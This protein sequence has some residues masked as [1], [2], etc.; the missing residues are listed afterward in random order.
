[1]EYKN[2]LKGVLIFEIKSLI[3]RKIIGKKPKIFSNKNYLNLGCGSNYVDGYINADFFYRFK[4]WKKYTKKLEWQLDLRYPLICDDCVFDGVYSEHTFEHLYPDEVQSLLKELYRVMKNGAILRITV[5]DLE[6]YV[7]FYNRDKHIK[8]EVFRE[9]Y[10]TG[11]SAIRNM[12]QNYFHVSAW[13]Y[14]ELKN[15]L[16]NIGYKEIEKMNYAQTRDKQLNLDLKDRA[17]ETL[18]VEAIK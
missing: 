2:S 18:Y 7:A 15:L 1:M 11:C 17:W 14:E 12:T 5:P 8:Q 16:K 9:K 13:D 3:G 10:Q 6:K 4:I